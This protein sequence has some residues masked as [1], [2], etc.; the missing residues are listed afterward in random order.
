MPEMVR[1]ANE[2]PDF[3]R[4]FKATLKENAKPPFSYGR[5]L[6]AF[7]V[8]YIYGQ[9]VMIA[10]PESD[11]AGINWS[12]L[13]WVIP[14]AVSLGI[15]TVGNVGRE[16]GSI[17]KCLITAYAVYPIRYFVYDETY[18]FTIVIGACALVFDNWSKEW[19]L[20]PPKR[21]TLK[22]RTLA[23]TTAVCVYLALWG[24]YVYF[25]GQ[26]TD[27]D[28]DVV[29]VHEAIRNVLT[30][31]WWTDLKQTCSDTW[32]YARHHGWYETWKQI[33]D[34]LDADGEQNAFKV[35]FFYSPL[36]TDL[37]RNFTFFC[38]FLAFYQLPRSQRSPQP[39]DVC[40]RK[41]ILIRS[42]VMQKNDLH[43]IDSWKFHRPTK[44]SAR[45]S[46]S[47]ATR[48]RNIPKKNCKNTLIAH[49]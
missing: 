42:R 11:F 29:P 7:A 16:Q 1:D 47:D 18:W 35:S 21:R 8:A 9:V 33:I 27:S 15:W 22:R 4:R 23:L 36:T 10:I 45:L 20:E 48:T 5:F 38:R 31:P 49:I 28:G 25:N 40:P 26:V 19:L 34:T 6:G 46:Q 2:D 30:S 24:C 37:I 44:R 12:F 39:F 14:F 32:Q 13:H 43:R 3:V 41:T 17:W